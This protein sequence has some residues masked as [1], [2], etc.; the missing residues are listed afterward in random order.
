MTGAAAGSVVLVTGVGRASGAGAAAAAL[1]CAGSETDRAALLVELGTERAPRPTLLATAG[2]RQLEERLAA[3]LTGA[4]LAARGRICQLTLP[5][6]EDGEAAFD[7]LDA[8]LPLVRDSL[9]VVHLPPR[10]LQPLLAEARARPTAA[11]LRADLPAQRPLTALAVRDLLE[12]GIEV[13]VLKRP[14]GWLAGRAALLGALPDAATA[15]PARAG[16]LLR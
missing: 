15:L 13:A 8:A 2:A 1:A 16:R 3:H 4:L 9:A 10:L 7:R 11:L 5:G 12:R 14:L 6:E